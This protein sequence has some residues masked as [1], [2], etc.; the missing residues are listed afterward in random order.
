MTATT[1][2]A[3]DEPRKRI[4]M[5]VTQA[6]PCLQRLLA[7]LESVF[8]VRFEDAPVDDLN[9]VDAAL[10]LD[11]A[12]LPD[13]PGGIPRLVVPPCR[14]RRGE[15]AVVTLADDVRLQGPL[16]GRAIPE[17]A[18]A[19]E[20]PLL[21]PRPESV[22]AASGRRPVWWQASEA[23]E[24]TSVSAPTPCPRRPRERLSVTI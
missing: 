19:A 9:G 16:R 18:A 2:L 23:H 15:G 5:I 4:G 10:V 11:P 8:P 6:V 7:P 1:D 22:L 20:L 13:T 3:I 12:C 24:P 21:P 14:E 17:D